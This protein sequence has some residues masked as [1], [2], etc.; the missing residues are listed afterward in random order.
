M[1]QSITTTGVQLASR[2]CRKHG[3][4]IGG[5][6]TL[7]A[8]LERGPLKM[9]DLA[10]ACGFTSASATGM[11]DRLVGRALVSREDGENGD[12]RIVMCRITSK[13]EDLLKSFKALQKP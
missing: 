7:C 8:L 10:L 9:T 3:L 12:R 6:A 2:F 1:N 4:S 11:L 5:L 13:G